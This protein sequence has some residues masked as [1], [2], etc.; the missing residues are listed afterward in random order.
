MGS[1]EKPVA[2]VTGASSGIGLG[3]AQA[4]LERGFRVVGT[5]RSITK[6]KELKAS[7]DLVLVD[8]GRGQ[9]G[10]GGEGG[11]S[12]GEAFWPH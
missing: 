1:K 10:D 4:L 11:G 8:G 12:G 6:S 5:S 3:M 2:I 9:E 7:S